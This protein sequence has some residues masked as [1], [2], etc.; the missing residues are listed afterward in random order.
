MASQFADLYEKVDGTNTYDVLLDLAL[1]KTPVVRRR[2]GKHAFAASCVLRTFANALVTRLPS[3]DDIARVHARYPDVRVEVLATEGRRLSQEMQD[4][5]SFRYGI[6][7]IGGRDRKDVLTIFDR[8]QTMLSFGLL[9]VEAPSRE[10]KT[11]APR[12]GAPASRAS[13]S[14]A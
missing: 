1:G 3:A 6:L 12:P 4:G 9:P 11:E 8:C 7:N 14:A 2:A 10:I 13:G 5:R